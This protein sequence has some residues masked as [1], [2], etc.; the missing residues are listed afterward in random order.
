MIVGFILIMVTSS[1]SLKKLSE[2]S[3]GGPALPVIDSARVFSD[4]EA[5]SIATI[6]RNLEEEVGSQIVV[7][8]VE[9]LGNKNM[10]AYSFQVAT[11]LGVGR[12]TQNDGILITLAMAER[13]ARIEV[14]TGL[15]NI[16]RDEIAAAIIREQMAPHFRN[17]QYG[18]GVY[19]AT[20]KIADLIRQN[21]TLIGSEPTWKK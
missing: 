15:E 10:E 16:I 21:R 20:L 8:T 6:I 19:E 2:Q 11:N 17:D 18:K 5:D 9:G 12:V 14:G 13:K 3:E 4:G 7:L 1:C